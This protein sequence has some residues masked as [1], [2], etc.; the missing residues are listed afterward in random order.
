M[1]KFIID[2]SP[3]DVLASCGDY[4]CKLLNSDGCFEAVSPSARSLRTRVAQGNCRGGDLFINIHTAYFARNHA[5]S[6]A[7]YVL[8]KHTETAE[9]AEK[10]LK[11]VSSKLGLLNDGV[12]ENKSLFILNNTV[13]P[14]AVIEF[15]LNASD[16]R[17]VGA[18]S[19][20][21]AEALHKGIC[22]HFSCSPSFV[23]IAEN[24]SFNNYLSENSSTGYIKVQTLA[25]RSLI[26]VNSATVTVTKTLDGQNYELARVSTD[27]NGQT[28]IIALPTKSAV[29]SQSP[30]SVPPFA[31]YDIKAEHPEFSSV[32]NVNVPIFDS[33]L[34][35]QTMRMNSPDSP[36]KVTDE[37]SFE[38]LMEV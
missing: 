24:N 5:G 26:P 10:I 22:R 11:E 30:A 28:G 6:V 13:M 1:K 23:K 3:M 25:G 27:A 14:S 2:F 34:S 4:L 32:K 21:A 29:L 8:L 17:R 20:S 37:E 12:R 18:L 7:A 31:V 36:E 9:L 35:I 15:S 38:N 19:F 16:M 33:V